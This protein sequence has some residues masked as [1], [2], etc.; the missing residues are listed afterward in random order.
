MGLVNCLIPVGLLQAGEEVSVYRGG[1]LTALGI[2][3][4]VKLLKSGKSVRLYLADGSTATYSKNQA[5][6]VWRRVEKEKDG[7]AK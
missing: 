7:R 2:V 1:R 6:Y 4:R 5:F 3:H